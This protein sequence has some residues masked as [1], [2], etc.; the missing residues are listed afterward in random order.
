MGNQFSGYASVFGRLLA[1]VQQARK[2][3]LKLPLGATAIGTGY[4]AHPEFQST[5]LD[6]L[7]LIT[8]LPLTADANLF[9]ALQN[10][11]IWLS[12]SATLK[13]VAVSLNKLA[14][15]LR[16]MSSGPR[17]GLNEI[18]LPAVQP[19]SSIMP[20]K[21]NPVMPEMMMQVYF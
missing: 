16:L 13:A 11:D 15:D 12:I 4:G 18:S 5:V 19:G 1:Q 9:D 20:G 21:V 7:S 14:S 6:E 3:C 2:Q 8:G 10:A 17:A